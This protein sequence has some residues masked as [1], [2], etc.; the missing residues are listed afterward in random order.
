[1]RIN[2]QRGFTTKRMRI[3]SS[4]NVQIVFN[5]A[6]AWFKCRAVSCGSTTRATVG[7]ERVRWSVSQRE[8][9][10]HGTVQG[11][12]QILMHQFLEQLQTIRLY[13]D[14]DTDRC[15]SPQAVSLGIELQR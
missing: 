8:Y 10:N 13:S 15:E 4:G 7:I 12:K 9:A 1:M 6:V 14:G 2:G 11:F 5:L 3:D